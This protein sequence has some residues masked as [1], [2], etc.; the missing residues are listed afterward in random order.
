[1]ILTRPWEVARAEAF[2]HALVQ[3][4]SDDVEI[5]RLVCVADRLRRVAPGP[6]DQEFRSRLR[7]Q[8]MHEAATRQPADV[9]GARAGRTPR[10]AHRA[11]R[12]RRAR[13][14]ISAVVASAALACGSLGLVGGSANALPGEA[15]Y[16]VKR[17]V[18][19]SRLALT[20]DDSANG[21]AR[22][23]LAQNRL[24]EVER[25]AARQDD[26]GAAEHLG[27][28]LDAFA[29]QAEQGATMLF[30]SYREGDEP[31]AVERVLSFA[32]TASGTLARLSEGLPT[33]VAGPY[34][35]AAEAVRDANVRAGQV[36]ITC[37]ISPLDDMPDTL[38]PPVRYLS[39]PSQDPSP[40]AEQPREAPS[41]EVSAEP[42][43]PPA[44]PEVDEEPTPEPDAREVAPVDKLPDRP[45]VVSRSLEKLGEGVEKL[46]EPLRER[47]ESLTE[48]RR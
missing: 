2:D 11:P 34:E 3:G 7:G 25:L 28:T 48:R 14:K 17:G 13:R 38:P 30:R 43:S 23:Q 6:P 31:A 26:P 29:A 24:L 44:T 40:P 36:C 39:G 22:L 21:V 1:M 32:R 16:P 5:A 15:L 4:E 27:R 33:S 20:R 9:P 12:S 45:D 8:L 41:P 47:A 18:E 42:S 35:A 37:S 10:R 46:T 19:G